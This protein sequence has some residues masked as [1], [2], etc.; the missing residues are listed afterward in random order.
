MNINNHHQQQ[1]TVITSLFK[2][3]RQWEV[4]NKNKQDVYDRKLN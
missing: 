4:D 3:H 2:L 1:H